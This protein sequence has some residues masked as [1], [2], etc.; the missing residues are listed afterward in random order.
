MA[1]ALGELRGLS[2]GEANWAGMKR[3][4]T[5]V[6]LLA[7]VAWGDA[8]SE[9]LRPA[10]RSQ[11]GQ[12][13]RYATVVPYKNTAFA[14]VTDVDAETRNS[15]GKRSRWAVYEYVGGRWSFVFAFEAG[16]DA[17]EESAR[18]DA[19]F[20]KHRFSSEMRGKLMYGDE[21]RL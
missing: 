15:T 1:V 9:R 12:R 6:L 16:V 2:S 14:A 17:D 21:T 7:A 10:V 3:F 18:L 8:L 13:Y 5:L 11:F 19:L 4:V 20:G